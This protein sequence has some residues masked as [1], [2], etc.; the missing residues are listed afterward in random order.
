MRRSIA[1]LIFTALGAL[2]FAGES[3]NPE[4]DGYCAYSLA[5]GGENKTGCEVVWIS[6]EDKLYCF[7]N[8]TAKNE[9]VK[10]ATRNIRKAKAFWEDPAFWE[11]LKKE[12]ES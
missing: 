10:D 3:R 5:N 4:F 7:M 2:A 8:E 6:P 9:F 1:A 12:E 11:K